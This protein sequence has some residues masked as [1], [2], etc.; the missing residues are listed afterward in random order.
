MDGEMS[1]KCQECGKQYK[2]DLDIPDELWE[3]IQPKNKPKGA[4]LLCGSCIMKKIEEI[5]DYDYWY[6]KKGG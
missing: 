6:L 3:K 2:V 5:S 4:G 1:C